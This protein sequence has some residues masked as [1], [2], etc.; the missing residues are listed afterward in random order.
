MGKPGKPNIVFIFSDQ[1]HWRAF[2][3][4]SPFFATPNMDRLAAEGAVFEQAFCTTPQ[5]SPSR[6]TLMTG[7][8]PHKTGVVGN[9]GACL[10]DVQAL[11]SRTVGAM[12][13]DAGYHT[14]YFGKWHLGKHPVGTSGWDEDAGV[15]SDG[16]PDDPGTTDLAL[17][18]LSRRAY[19]DAPFALFLSYVNPHDIY[20][21]RPPAE[22][23]ALDGVPL[24]ESWHAESFADKPGV[25]LQFMTE[26]QG[27]RLHGKPEEHWREYRRFYREKVRLFDVELGRVLDG[28]ERHGLMDDAV[29]TVT[30]DHGD[31]DTSHRLIFKGPFMYEHMVRVP[32]VVRVPPGRGGGCGRSIPGMTVGTDLVPTILD[33]AGARQVECDGFSLHPA[34]TGV[35]PMPGREFVIGQYY[36]KQ[37]WINPIRMLRT[38]RYKYTRYVTH[39]EELYDLHEDP[40][41]LVNLAGHPRCA[42]TIGEL[43]RR[44]D[45]WMARNDDPF[46]TY[47]TST[48]DGV[49]RPPV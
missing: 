25:Q 3:R 39:G 22:G 28:I 38:E 10:G 32:L 19:G 36:G 15:T 12:L 34:L 29:L 26:D 30:S 47:G 46:P 31:M 20:L 42:G 9:I 45:E 35:G 41:E 44:L 43:S 1:Q 2:G 7:L 14:A 49:R 18:Y 40:N 23:A 24:P 13:Q 33:F 11:A 17:D 8:Y 21:V 48:R 4:A 16:P 37:K 6:A 27:T 5:C